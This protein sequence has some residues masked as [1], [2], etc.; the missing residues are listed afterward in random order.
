MDLG[1]GFWEILLILIIAFIAF[2]PGKMVEIAREGGKA[3]HKIKSFTQGL[4]TEL[5]K[6]MDATDNAT[7]AEAKEKDKITK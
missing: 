2:G 4:K 1:I 3:I 7:E 6:E 5:T